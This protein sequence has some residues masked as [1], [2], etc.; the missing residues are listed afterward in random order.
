MCVVDDEGERTAEPGSRHVHPAAGVSI[1]E[2]QVGLGEHCVIAFSSNG[3]EWSEEK[4]E[5]V[6]V[7][8]V[9]KE[10][11][12]RNV[13]IETL[14]S[15]EEEEDLSSDY[16]SGGE[17]GLEE[18]SQEER[19]E[20]VGTEGEEGNTVSH[21]DLGPIEKVCE[22]RLEMEDVELDEEP[23]SSDDDRG[24]V[25]ERSRGRERVRFA[26]TAHGEERS[27]VARFLPLLRGS[28]KHLAAMSYIGD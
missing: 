7:V 8:P 12:V 23:G 2:E 16:M 25:E 19:T 15:E 14:G 1:T 6:F 17:D 13:R 11:P 3:G 4:K 20:R 21:L 28:G 18:I 22:E 24:P 26:S 5:N 9:A 10:I 27:A